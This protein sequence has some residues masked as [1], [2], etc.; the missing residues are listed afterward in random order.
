MILRPNLI[1]LVMGF[2]LYS[3]AVNLLLPGAV[4]EEHVD[5]TLYISNKTVLVWMNGGHATAL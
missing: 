5:A 2:G 4:R 3:N 1:R